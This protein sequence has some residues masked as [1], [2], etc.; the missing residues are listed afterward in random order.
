MKTH[1][2]NV[3]SLV[4][5][6]IFLGLSGAWLLR[7]WDVIPDDATEW[8]LPVLLVGAGLI[9]LVAYAARSVW[10]GRDDGNGETT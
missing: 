9:G 1:Q 4:V 5:G 2:T 7:E 3:S 10:P 6:L 8:I